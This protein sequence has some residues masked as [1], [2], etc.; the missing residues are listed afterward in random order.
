MT[1]DED[2]AKNCRTTLIPRILSF[3]LIGYERNVNRCCITVF[4][5]FVG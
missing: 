5:Y 1:A 2:F 3:Y 4:I